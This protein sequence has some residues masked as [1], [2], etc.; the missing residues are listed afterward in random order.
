LVRALDL[1]SGHVGYRFGV[2]D[3]IHH[4][5]P[6]HNGKPLIEDLLSHGL[7]LID[8]LI[9][10]LLI[11]KVLELLVGDPLFEERHIIPDQAKQGH[12][13]D[14]PTLPDKGLSRYTIQKDILQPVLRLPAEGDR[15]DGLLDDGD[16]DGVVVHPDRVRLYSVGG[17]V[18]LADF[19]DRERNVQQGGVQTRQALLKGVRVGARL[20][21]RRD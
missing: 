6:P 20:K 19:E 15:R 8:T 1:S 4:H 10:I 14:K 3:G 13:P 11:I 16:I 9:P 2:S 7:N 5:G 17:I 18:W 12:Q 21:W